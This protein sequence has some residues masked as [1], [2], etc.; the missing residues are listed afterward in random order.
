[1]MNDDDDDDMVIFII[2]GKE[3]QGR[4]FGNMFVI[5]VF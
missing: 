5:M 2:K 3:V 1:M 4:Q